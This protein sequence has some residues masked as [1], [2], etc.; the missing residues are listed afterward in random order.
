MAYSIAIARMSHLIEHVFVSTD[1]AEIAEIA[2]KYRAEVPFLRPIEISQDDSTDLEF[3]QH[4][5][6]TL[7][8]KGIKLPDRIVHLRPTTPLRETHI[9]NLAIEKIVADPTATSLR[10]VHP[11]HITPYKM[12]QMEGKYLKGFYPDDPSEYY[13]L[14]RQ[15]FPR[16]YMPNGYI[17]I[18]KPSTIISGALHGNAMLGFKTV[19]VPDID[20]EEDFEIAEKLLDDVRFKDLGRFLEKG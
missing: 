14:P 20:V 16:S 8:Q 7:S 17:D 18:V 15:A 6:K 5:M 2:L 12:F 9:V 1:S 3:F 10:S 11:I 4:F 13:N 19:K